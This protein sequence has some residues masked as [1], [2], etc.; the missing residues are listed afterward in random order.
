MI[1]PAKLKEEFVRCGISVSDSEFKNILA[2]YHQQSDSSLRR[3]KM[4][5]TVTPEYRK[6]LSVLLEMN[7]SK[8]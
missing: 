1:S 2:A 4:Y 7:S 5:R 6:A 3:T 8:D